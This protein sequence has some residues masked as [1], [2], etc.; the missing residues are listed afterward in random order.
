MLEVEKVAQGPPG[1]D[2]Y[3]DAPSHRWGVE[4]AAKG[5]GAVSQAAYLAVGIQRQ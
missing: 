1:E 3:E 2:D 5:V 4:S